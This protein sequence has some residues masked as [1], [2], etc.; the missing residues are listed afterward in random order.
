MLARF[1]CSDSHLGTIWSA[2][3]DEGIVENLDVSQ[4]AKV[5]SKMHQVAKEL[6]L[7][8][9]DDGLVSKSKKLIDIVIPYVGELKSNSRRFTPPSIVHPKPH[10]PSQPTTVDAT[11]E[12]LKA[13]NRE[14]FDQELQQRRVEFEK[15][16]TVNIPD[17]PKFAD[18]K[19]D[20]NRSV[21]DL[22]QALEE[23]RNK[24]LRTLQ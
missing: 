10:E 3:H 1:L 12:S 14:V 21:S 15:L 6:A 20:D 18:E 17:E 24:Q 22:L 4:C 2:L 16:V 8:G 7:D 9:G 11:A 19:D 5:K 13:H 23:D